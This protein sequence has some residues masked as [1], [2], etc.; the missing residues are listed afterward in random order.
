MHDASLTRSA[1][2]ARTATREALARALTSS[3]VDTLATFE[4]YARA[5]PDLAVPK[6]AEFNPPLWELGHIG[7][8]HEYWI[9]RNEVPAGFRS[10]EA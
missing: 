6:R 7:W 2:E 10:C 3:L 8:F 1:I 4:A 5:L 9:A